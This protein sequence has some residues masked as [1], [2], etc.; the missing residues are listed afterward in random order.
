MAETVPI[1]DPSN[2][3]AANALLST[4][5]FIPQAR[6]LH[7][8]LSR[9]RLV[10]RLKTGLTRQLT[11]LSAPAGFGKTTLL[12]EW[13]PQSDLCVC[14]LSLDEADNDL[15]RFLTYFI[16]ALQRLKADFG[17][18]ALVVL[19]SP[20]PPTIESLMTA[21]VNEI[22]QTL[23]E[24]ALVLDDYHLIHLPAI[25]ALE[26]Y[27]PGGCTG[28]FTRD[29]FGDGHGGAKLDADITNPLI[30]H[31]VGKVLH[32]QVMNA[33]SNRADHHPAFW[34]FMRKVLCFRHW[35]CSTSFNSNQL[36]VKSGLF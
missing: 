25:H 19:Q 2:H 33:R 16:A 10:E 9:P 6:Q 14:W 27:R 28:F 11:L 29:S 8:M 17:Q 20:Q 36:A 34:S 26:G 23:A 22:I 32:T 31:P 4:K 18:I 15:T 1:I 5:L 21:L 7:D 12:T 3:L 13:I 35:F 24:F 30:L